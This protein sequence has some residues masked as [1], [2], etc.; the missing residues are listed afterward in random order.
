MD[1]CHMVYFGVAF[2]DEK[3]W[4]LQYGIR[5]NVGKGTLY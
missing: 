4:K 1:Y 3:Q 5:N 2:L